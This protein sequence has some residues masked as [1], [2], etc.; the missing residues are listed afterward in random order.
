M[1]RLKKS[2]ET[3]NAIAKMAFEFIVGNILAG[4]T[5]ALINTI[6]CVVLM[7]LSFLL[8]AWLF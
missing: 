1:S 2:I 8:G 6:V 4:L 7:V 5:R 3:V